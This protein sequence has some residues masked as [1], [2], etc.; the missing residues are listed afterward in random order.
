M[1][2]CPLVHTTMHHKIFKA[3]YHNYNIIH[4]MFVA[5]I[6]TY[7]FKAY[8]SLGLGLG[9]NIIILLI[10]QGSAKCVIL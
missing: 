3:T 4:T 9:S 8:S 2:A 5:R 10:T 7:E 1:Y 6:G